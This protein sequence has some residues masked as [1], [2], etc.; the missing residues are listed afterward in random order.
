MDLRKSQNS[1]KASNPCIRCGQERIE[2]ETWEET[3]TY[4][5]GGGTSILTHTKTVCPDPTCQ[6][7]V[8]EELEIQRIKREAYEQ[9]RGNRRTGLKR[10]NQTGFKITK[11]NHYKK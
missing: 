4:D 6:K 9:D 1:K 8:E 3:V 11:S 2:S 5:M 10:P 7:I